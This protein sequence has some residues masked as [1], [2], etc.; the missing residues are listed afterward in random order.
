MLWSIKD[1]QFNPLRILNLDQLTFPLQGLS[2]WRLTHSKL[3]AR[4]AFI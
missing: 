1:N 3:C 2:N 4:R